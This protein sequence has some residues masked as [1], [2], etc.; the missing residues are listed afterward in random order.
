MSEESMA[1]AMRQCRAPCPDDEERRPLAPA[2]HALS[3]WD[4]LLRSFEPSCTD[5][6]HEESS[7]V[8]FSGETVGGRAPT[9]PYGTGGQRGGS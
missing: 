8:S 2:G 7:R 1:R 4:A 9:W 3:L 5:T 6:I